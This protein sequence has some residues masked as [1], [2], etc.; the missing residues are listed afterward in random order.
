MTAPRPRGQAGFTLVELMISL[1]LFAFAMAGIL[2]VAA[3]MTQGFRD[4]RAALETESA[5]RS[6]LDFLADALRGASPAAPT[7]N[8]IDTLNATTCGVATPQAISVTNNYNNNG[9]DL[10]DVIYASG[11]VVTTSTQLWAGGST[12]TVADASQFEAG[13]AIVISNL[14]QGHFV[15]IASVSIGSNTLTF[16]ALCGTPNLPG[17]GYDAGSLVIRAQHAIFWVDTTTNTLMM[18]ATGDVTQNATASEPLAEGIEDLQVALG[19]DSDGNG[20]ITDGGVGST[21][22]EWQGNAT[23]D[24]V[25][26]GTLRAVRLS[27]VARELTGLPQVTTPFSRPTLEDHT[28]GAADNYPRRVLQSTIEVRNTTGSP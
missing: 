6:T 23:G 11:G 18:N 20:V 28:G 25:L 8:I 27:I 21:T 9:P 10:L 4:Q 24:A 22:D 26:T 1:V 7:G 15:R 17:S 13:D 16:S 14:T 19:I 3:S 5:A 12:L 2:A